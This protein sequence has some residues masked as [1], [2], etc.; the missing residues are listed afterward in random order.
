MNQRGIIVEKIQPLHAVHVGDAAAIGRLGVDGIG[1]M[2]D[3]G[4][5]VAA[6]QH[7]LGA[8]MK[9]GGLRRCVRIL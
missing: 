9:P 6:R 3:G 1:G 7:L 2:K 4:A 5:R 8:P